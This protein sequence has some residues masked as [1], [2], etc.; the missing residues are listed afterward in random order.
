MADGFAGM[1]FPVF[2]QAQHFECM[3]CQGGGSD[4]RG[5]IPA[6]MRNQQSEAGMGTGARLVAAMMTVLA[7]AGCGRQEAAYPSRPVTLVV[8]FT[9]AGASDILARLV[10]ERA[11]RALG[12]SIVIE[13]R[14]GAGGNVGTEAAARAPADG[15]TLVLCTIGTCAI[16]PAVF[17]NMPYDLER[18]FRAVI[19]FGSL[20][21]LLAVNSN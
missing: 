11:A 9:A 21:N 18:D 5:T 13:N 12:Q 7:L 3:W 10:S 2:Q 6:R 8:P 4:C 17:A 16:N 19:L 14:P 15:Y 1:E 20:S